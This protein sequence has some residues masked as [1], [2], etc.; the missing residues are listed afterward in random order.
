M[1]PP[2]KIV[3]STMNDFFKE[4]SADGFFLKKY[5][6][7]KVAQKI[8]YFSC[9]LLGCQEDEITIIHHTSEAFNFLSHGLSFE[10]GD[11]II[12]LEDEYPSNFYPWRHL[13]QKGVKL[14]TVSP[15]NTPDE[16]LQNL[17]AKLHKRTRLL[18][19]SAVHWISGMPFDLEKIGALCKERKVLFCVDGAQG[20]GMV[21]VDVNRCQIDFMATSAWK[22]LMGPLGAAL[23]YVRADKLD[24][25]APNII[26]TGS[27]VND[28][29]YLPYKDQL[30]KTADRFCISTP[31]LQ[32]WVYLM[33][34]M[35]YLHLLGHSRVQER[36]YDLAGKITAVLKK[37]GFH[38]SRPDPLSPPSAIISAKHSS[39]DSGKLCDQLAT[40]NIITSH[41]G[42][43]VRFSPHIENNEEQ[44]LTLDKILEK[45]FKE[46][47]EN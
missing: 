32:D 39:I 11:E 4:F 42:D 15:G 40:F 25:I 19:L 37:Y 30:K 2:S 13:T 43:Y 7:E 35:E 10:K 1:A 45:I 8:K 17:K 27:V 3:L 24:L 34:A 26:G 5:S 9:E 44:I 20:V 36:I 21:D 12:I 31:S 6:F 14:V 47:I 33:A 28:L 18:S 38:F 41:R 29:N 16:F 23:F 22:W 46:K